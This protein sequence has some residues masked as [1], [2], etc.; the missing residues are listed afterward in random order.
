MRKEEVPKTF[1]AETILTQQ[2]AM[3]CASY[4][5]ARMRVS[6][7]AYRNTPDY[8]NGRVSK[9][10]ILQ[11]RESFTKREYHRLQRGHGDRHLPGRQTGENV[12]CHSGRA[13]KRGRVRQ[14]ADGILARY[15]QSTLPVGRLGGPGRSKKGI[16]GCV[17]AA[18]IEDQRR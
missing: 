7:P 12:R 2:R 3:Q 18:C 4:R 10:I 11:Q 5:K 16:N 9:R 17:R 8:H 1:H 6:P 14:C 15:H 13:G